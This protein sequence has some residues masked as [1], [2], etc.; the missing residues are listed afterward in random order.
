MTTREEVTQAI[1][2]AVGA[3]TANVY[4]ISIRF[5]GEVRIGYKTKGFGPVSYQWYRDWVEDA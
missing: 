1:C 3:S 5:N 4:D 2:K